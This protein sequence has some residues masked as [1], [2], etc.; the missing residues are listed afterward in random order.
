MFIKSCKRSHYASIKTLLS[1]YWVTLVREVAI[2]TIE[3]CRQQPGDASSR[4]IW[5]VVCYLPNCTICIYKCTA[6]AAFLHAAIEVTEYTFI[7]IIV[8]VSVFRGVFA[9]L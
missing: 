3:M 2:V 8:S 9:I 7:G 5:K 4:L 1:G 6:D